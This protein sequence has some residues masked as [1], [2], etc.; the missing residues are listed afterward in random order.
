MGN[1]WGS[2]MTREEFIKAYAARSNLS[3]EWAVL[4]FIQIGDMYQ[5]AMPCGCGDES[6]EGWGMV[7][8][9]NIDSH[10]RMYAPDELR[11]AYLKAIGEPF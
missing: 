3:D 5:L 9:S 4:G 7:G 8:P 11:S 10:L 2:D 1:K 6:C